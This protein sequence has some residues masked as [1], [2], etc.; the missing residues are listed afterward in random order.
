M[1]ETEQPSVQTLLFCSANDALLNLRFSTQKLRRFD[2][3]FCLRGLRGCF[4]RDQTTLHE[5][6][7]FF[8][9]DWCCQACFKQQLRTVRLLPRG[10]IFL[11]VAKPQASFLAVDSYFAKSSYSGR[12]ETAER[13]RRY[14]SNT[15]RLGSSNCVVQ[16]QAI[17]VSCLEK[18]LRYFVLRKSIR[19]KHPMNC[20]PFE[21]GF[22]VGRCVADAHW[23]A[24]FLY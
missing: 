13:I 8:Q 9:N 14:P 17:A 21:Q 22:D 10:R 18:Q 11:T 24:F 4:W 16:W 19:H 5:C 6:N 1:A 20:S 2:R 3:C 12:L 15:V 7:K 23:F